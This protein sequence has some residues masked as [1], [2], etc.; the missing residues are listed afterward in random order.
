MQVFLQNPVKYSLEIGDDLLYVNDQ[1]GKEWYFEYGQKTHC[2]CGKEVHKVF[3]QNFCYDCFYRKPEAGDFILRPELSKAHLG[4]EDRDLEWEK[5]YQ[6][7][8]HIVYLADSGGLKVGVT[9]KEQMP[10]RWID[11]GASSA[12]ILA[13]TPNRYLAGELEVALKA[14][15]SDKTVVKKMLGNSLFQLDLAE[16][17]KRVLKLIP[18]NLVKYVSDKMTEPLQIS[19]PRPDGFEHQKSI[20]LEK[21][22]TFKAKLIGI[23][24]QYLLFEHGRAMNVR[25]Q[26]G[27]IVYLD[28]Q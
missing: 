17:K 4:I 19:Y 14:H 1:I 23:R 13:E 21:E 25:S 24:G 16:E 7:K 20:S 2:F 28:I 11:Q 15:L 12:I 26:S 6:L 22:P 5:N 8:P 27:K 10:T 3:R 9:R 18:E